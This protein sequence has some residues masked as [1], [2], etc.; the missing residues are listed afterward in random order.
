L[1]A[2][3]DYL[4]T[5]VKEKTKDLIH[6]SIKSF[7]VSVYGGELRRPNGEWETLANQYIEECRAEKRS[8]FNDLLNYVTWLAKKER[9]PASIYAYVN[10]TKNWITYSLDVDLTGRQRKILRC[11][12]PKGKRARTV[13]DDMTREKLKKIL[14]HCDTKGRALFLFLASSGIR[15]G[16]ALQLKLSDIDLE[17][18]PP[19]VTVRGEYTKAGDT[20]ITFI[21]KEAKTALGEWLKVR[22]A[23]MRSAVHRGIGF[24]RQRLRPEEDKRI[25][26]F[27]DTVAHDMWVRALKKAGLEERDYGTKRRTMRIHMLRKWFMSQLKLV[28]PETVVE[29]FAGHSGYLDEAYRRYRCKQ[30]ADL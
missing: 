16:E 20:Y 2:I 13:E 28:L 18:D 4:T 26:P 14:T 7:L 12:I 19:K 17:H 1:G 25:F 21:T 11:R 27:S 24:G 30:L 5:Y 22:E 29:A 15:I 23:Y 6:T 8:W 10:A 3:G 9:P